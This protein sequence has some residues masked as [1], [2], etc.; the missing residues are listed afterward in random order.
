MKR[1]LFIFL[2]LFPFMVEAVDIVKPEDIDFE[3][4]NFYEKERKIIIK[5]Q[6]GLDVYAKPEESEKVG[7]VNRDDEF[8]FMY[9][10]DRYV[11]IENDKITG[12]IDIKDKNVLLQSF[13]TFITT[14]KITSYC[15]DIPA[16]TLIENTYVKDIDEIVIFVNYDGCSQ[17]ISQL[18][19]NSII[20]MN[21]YN[22]Y[23]KYL[24][25]DEKTKFTKEASSN[26]EVIEELPKNTIVKQLAYYY[27]MSIDG[28]DL[29]ISSYSEDDQVFYVEY[30]GQKGW[31]HINSIASYETEEEAKK[32]IKTNDFW[33]Y[34]IGG[35][36]GFAIVF[37][38]Y[39]IKKSK[40]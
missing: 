3:N 28:D 38:F 30:E 27:K 13:D 32:G 6:D 19:H 7:H 24:V 33:S 8:T 9:V 15:G 4:R 36:V 21:N 22:G 5:E 26:S 40:E 37:I 14:K 39:K 1:L 10:K 35:I 25:L 18:E 17:F 31:I 11:F 29:K 16:N 34:I 23:E 20:S 2:L 12:W